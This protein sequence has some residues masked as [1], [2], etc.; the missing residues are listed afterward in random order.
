MPALISYLLATAPSTVYPTLDA[1]N[2]A[3][4]DAATPMAPVP[5][6][7]LVYQGPVYEK[8]VEA[9]LPVQAP[10]YQEIDTRCPTP[11]QM[12]PYNC[13]DN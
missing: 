1:A 8:I 10:A 4:F 6:S 5:A 13:M 3:L 9:A 2:P 12:V 7:A 11:Y